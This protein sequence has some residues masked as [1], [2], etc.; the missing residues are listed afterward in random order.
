[1]GF[2][3]HSRRRQGG[4]IIVI[5][6]LS[7]AL[8]LA[9]FGLALDAARLYNR[10]VDLQAVADVAAL[11]AARQLVGTSDGVDLALSAAAS[12]AADQKYNY[13]KS[14]VVWSDAAVQFS[15]SPS[16]P[17]RD[18]SSARANPQRLLF[19]KVDTAGLGKD[20][21]SFDTVF[22]RV[23]PS[24]TKKASTSAKAVAGRASLNV[25][26]IGICAMSPLPAAPRL[27]TGELVQY[28]FPRGVGYDLM[29]LNPSLTAS[30]PISYTISPFN[31]GGAAS[32]TSAA[33]VGPYVCGGYMPAQGLVNESVRV[34]EKFK[35]AQLH[36]HLNSRFA[37][38]P[39]GACD[40]RAAPPDDNVTPY[41][42]G[43]TAFWMANSPKNQGALKTT[44]RGRYETIADLPSPGTDPGQL[45]ILWSFAKPVPF[46]QYV[47]GEAEPDEGYAAYGT[48][49]WRNL[50][51][52]AAPA[53]K[54]DYPDETPYQSTEEPFY[55]LPPETYGVPVSFRRV[56]N[57]PLLAC[58][59][60]G[61]SATVLAIGRFLMTVPA[62]DKSLQV[63]FGG[64]AAEKNLRGPVELYK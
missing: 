43:N 4:A 18:G 25:T 49:S 12:A 13:G 38:Y 37:Q 45:G 58:P 33:V 42:Y 52:P 47:P 61:S 35:L 31:S 6:A 19:V 23:L 7:L 34:E 15:E 53:A 54:S 10:K 9:M 22:L 55:T 1:M 41:E 60:S 32:A 56:L 8:I 57:V 40:M 28:G 3:A 63:E 2:T 24:G 21:G 26:P 50:Y 20:P 30:E 36:E 27:L 11:S 48:A 46:S 16:G 14:E 51:L 5:F 44:A 64:L 17:W 62:T 39:T 29:Q 59:V